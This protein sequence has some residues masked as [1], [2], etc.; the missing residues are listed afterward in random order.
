MTP[1]TFVRALAAVRLPNVFNRDAEKCEVY[2]Q[3]D[4]PAVRRRNLLTLL[5][6][7]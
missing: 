3:D 6:A 4:S 5:A 2:D 1:T 7:A